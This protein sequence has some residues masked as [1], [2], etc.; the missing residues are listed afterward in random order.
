[1][2]R[3]CNE[4]IGGLTVPGLFIYLLRA[5]NNCLER[6]YYEMFLKTNG[7]FFGENLEDQKLS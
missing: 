5:V 1:M 6:K 7:Y 4:F 2:K 3:Y